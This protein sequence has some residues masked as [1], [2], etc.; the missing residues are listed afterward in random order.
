VEQQQYINSGMT[1]SSSSN[2]CTTTSPSFTTVSYDIITRTYS[3]SLNFH[4]TLYDDIFEN[5][6]SEDDES[7]HCFSILISPTS[8]YISLGEDDDDNATV[9]S[10]ESTEEEI[11]N[12]Y[13]LKISRLQSL[14]EDLSNYNQ[15]NNNS[16]DLEEIKNKYILEINDA[17]VYNKKEDSEGLKKLYTAIIKSYKKAN[18]SS[19]KKTMIADSL[20]SDNSQTDQKT[21]KR[22]CSSNSP[23]ERSHPKKKTFKKVNMTAT[24]EEPTMNEEI[25]KSRKNYNSDTID[26]LMNWYLVNDGKPPTNESKQ[27]LA[28]LTGKSNI[29]SK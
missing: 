25:K 16:N 4:L 1:N 17:F 20:K 11:Q 7:D 15:Q 14:L 9:K 27:S 22:K 3:D 10:T 18:T 23:D 29:Q 19:K 13:N 2:Q 5:N 26:T 24:E 28:K 21:R 12:T 6:A 8:D